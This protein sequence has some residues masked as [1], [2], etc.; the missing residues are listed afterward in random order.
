MRK[1]KG[2]DANLGSSKALTPKGMITA[3]RTAGPSRLIETRRCKRS[4]RFCR[5]H[6]GLGLV[7]GERTG[8]N[9]SSINPREMVSN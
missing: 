3:W 2:S 9:I 8:L 7:A 5:Q 1:G 4:T 6:I